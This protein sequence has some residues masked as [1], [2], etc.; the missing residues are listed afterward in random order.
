[1]FSK[2]IVTSDKKI[3]YQDANHILRKQDSDNQELQTTLL[4]LQAVAEILDKKYKASDIYEIMKTST[5][6]RE[7]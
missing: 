3:S 4:N 1:M 6:P 2:S 5:L 7:M